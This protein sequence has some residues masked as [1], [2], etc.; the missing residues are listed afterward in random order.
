MVWSSRLLLNT[1]AAL[2]TVRQLL[3]VVFCLS[4]VSLNVKKPHTLAP[5]VDVVIVFYG[6]LECFYDFFGGF[7]CYF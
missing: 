3:L 2:L 4:A 7:F 5:L 6:L 1:G